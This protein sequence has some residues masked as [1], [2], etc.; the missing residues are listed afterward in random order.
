MSI[1]IRVYEAPLHGTALAND[2][3]PVRGVEVKLQEIEP[4]FLS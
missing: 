3:V 2:T 4:R 1:G